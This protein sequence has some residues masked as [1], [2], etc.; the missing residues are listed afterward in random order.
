MV[1]ELVVIHKVTFFS[2]LYFNLISAIAIEG[3]TKA[4]ILSMLPILLRE[5]W[6][7]RRPDGPPKGPQEKEKAPE[8]GSLGERKE[9]TSFLFW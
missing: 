4:A 5:S 8:T 9:T 3:R 1:E 7:E 6:L 2:L